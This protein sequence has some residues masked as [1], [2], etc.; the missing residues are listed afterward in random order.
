MQ[1][2]A[3]LRTLVDGPREK[4]REAIEALTSDQWDRN[5]ILDRLAQIIAEQ[6]QIVHRD[7]PDGLKDGEPEKYAE[8][9]A[10]ATAEQAA[11][12]TVLGIL[13]PDGLLD[14]GRFVDLIDK[15]GML[16]RLDH[17]PDH[18]ERMRDQ[19][20]VAAKVFQSR[21][22]GKAIDKVKVYGLGGSGAPH[23]IVA[24]IISNSRSSGTEIEVVHADEPNAD[25]VDPDTLVI[26][27]SF[28]GNTEETINCY[29]TIKHKRPLLAALSRG[30]K[31]RDIARKDGIPFMRIPGYKEDPAYV[32]QPRESVCLQ[33][34]ASLAFLASIG[35][36]PGSG[37]ALI[38]SDVD[39][40]FD[41]AQESLLPD[42]R[43]RIGPHVSYEDNLA[44]QLAF[45]LLYGYDGRAEEQREPNWIWDKKVPF[46]LTDRN[47]RALGHEVR[48]QMHE[49]SKLNAAFYDA[50]EFL[51]NLVE[52]IRAGS[53]SAIGGLDDD[54]WVYYFIRS[55]DEE[56]RIRLRL[57]KTIELVMKEKAKYAVLNVDEETPYQNALF[58]TYFNAYM[59][60]YLAILNGFDPLPVP[61]MS[62]IKNVM[63]A[64][65]RGGE[66]ERNA[67]MHQ[68]EEQLEMHQMTV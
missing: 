10:A 60:T 62:W 24:E 40:E 44:K 46:V 14:S 66:E 18:I 31:L 48:T 19:A 34:T 13:G 27:S 28:S 2:L 53:E 68:I 8:I 63:E 47:H 4:R 45:F 49:R 37:G 26:L 41:K 29:E 35:L 64:Y 61:T 38:R 33:M 39:G 3:H 55:P 51:H 43:E 54:R 52:S 22:Q 5:E 11:V 23:D 32:M 65:P 50:P 57:D 36:T 16:K 20:A 15:T 6:S 7:T 56:P 30:G 12:Q 58:A 21:H 1:T 42:W 25:H 9:I 67:Q 59:T 17:W